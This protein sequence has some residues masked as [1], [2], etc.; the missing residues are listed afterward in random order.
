MIGLGDGGFMPLSMTV[1]LALNS[2][3]RFEF[4]KLLPLLLCTTPK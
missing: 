3:V 1:K 2:P 4:V